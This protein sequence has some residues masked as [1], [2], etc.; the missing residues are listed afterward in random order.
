MTL[1]GLGH[2]GWP[3]LSKSDAERVLRIVRGPNGDDCQRDADIL[4]EVALSVR[5]IKRKTAARPPGERR[6]ALRDEAKRI[7]AAIKSLKGLPDTTQRQLNLEAFQREYDRTLA[8]ADE[9]KVTRSG[10]K[11]RGPGGGRVEAAQKRAAAI[12][13]QNM[14]EGG[15]RKPRNFARYCE[16]AAL[17]FELATGKASADMEKVCRAR[18]QARG[19]VTSAHFEMFEMIFLDDDDPKVFEDTD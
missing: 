8:L 6:T 10:G 17:L 13:A 16:L 7:E 15:G 2:L 12:C 18:R 19:T 1:S 5:W 3:P 9:I 4:G 11:K 14:S